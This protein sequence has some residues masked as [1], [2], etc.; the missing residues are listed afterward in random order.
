M[1]KRILEAMKEQR[2]LNEENDYWIVSE[3]V[4]LLLRMLVLL[5]KPKV[6]LEIGTSIG[7]SSLWLAS[8]LQ[9]GGKLITIESHAERF[10]IG[11][12]FFEES[13]LQDKIVHIKHHAPECYKDIE[14]NIDMV[15]SDAVKKG[16]ISY[17]EEL[18][19]KLNNGA[20]VVTDNINSHK[21]EMLPFLEYMNNNSAFVNS[22]LDIGTGLLLS[23]YSTQQ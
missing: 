1:D 17:V 5:K 21:E 13:G 8:A 3:E 23:V 12:A 18:I 22:N 9:E 4:G 7:Y 20:L 16:S 10:E 11:E 6:I 14:E 2:V 19:P 15:F